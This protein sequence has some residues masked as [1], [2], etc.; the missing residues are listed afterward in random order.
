MSLN[1]R[2]DNSALTSEEGESFAAIVLPLL[3]RPQPVLRLLQLG[4]AQGSGKQQLA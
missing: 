2:V 4:L 1:K 3:P